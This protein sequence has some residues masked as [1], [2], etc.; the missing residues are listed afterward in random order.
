MMWGKLREMFVLVISLDNTDIFDNTD[1]FLNQL[2][3]FYSKTRRQIYHLTF[4]VCCVA[5]QHRD[6]IVTTD[7]CDVT[8]PYA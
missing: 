7:Y 4:T 8:S 1:V 3:Q 6:R 2:V 5:P